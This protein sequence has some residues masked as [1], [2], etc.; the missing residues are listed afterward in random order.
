MNIVKRIIDVHGGEI[1]L[2]EPKTL[3]GVAI[4]IC[5]PCE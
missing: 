2:V 5:L 3:C 1:S 4:E